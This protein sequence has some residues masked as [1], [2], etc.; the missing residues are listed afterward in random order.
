MLAVLLALLAG[1]LFGLVAVVARRAIRAGGSPE[2][3]A[4]AGSSTG[5][6]L[7][8]IAAAASGIGPGD[9]HW[10]EL[11][12]FLAVGVIVPGVANVLF[13]LAVRAIGPSRVGVL[14]GTVPLLSVLIAMVALDERPHPVLWVGTVL[15]VGGGVVLAWDRSRPEG[16]RRIGILLALVCAV[17][18][19]GRDNVV[20][21][22][23]EGRH[24]PPLAAAAAT[25]IAAAVGSLAYLLL[26][27]RQGLAQAILPSYRRFAMPGLCIGIAYVAL[28]E[29]FDKGDVSVVAPLNA[30]QSLWAVAFSWAFI[31]RVSEA[32]GP[33]LLG[34]AALVV[35]GSA[36]VGVFR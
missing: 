35:A 30:T 22:A 17:L 21:W 7:A 33:R 5:A 34:A 25:L 16:F 1:V 6:V 15:I 23:A 20:R 4:F 28:V 32:I 10:H 26:F 9:L 11:W 2:V 36:I 29:A 3:G 24:T 31:G 13:N 12:P 14:V 27:K 18:F 19:A 8:V